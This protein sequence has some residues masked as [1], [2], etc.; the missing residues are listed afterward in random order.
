M[1][2]LSRVI[3]KLQGTEAK[4]LFQMSREDLVDQLG[5]EEGAKLYDELQVQIGAQ[6]VSNLL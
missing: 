5:E 2:F 6:T 4:K 1:R 3:E